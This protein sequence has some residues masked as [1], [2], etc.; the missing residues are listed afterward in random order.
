MVQA[1][2]GISAYLEGE[3]AG[4]GFPGA[5]YV[6]G[7]G[8]DV[9]YADALGYAVVEPEPIDACPDTIY[10]LASLTKPLVTSLLAVIMHESGAW[11]LSAPVAEYLFECESARPLSLTDLL[12]H[13]SGL[14][15]WRPLY[16]ETEDPSM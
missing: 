6:I 8:D 11:D 2:T 5:Q 12:T 16:L 4:G 9:V 14:P 3:I 15:N 7:R 13:T 10:D 1:A